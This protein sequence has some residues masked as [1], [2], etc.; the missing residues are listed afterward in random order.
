MTFSCLQKM[1]N[2]RR[3]NIN[4]KNI[5]LGYR[6]GIYNRKMYHIYNEKVKKTNN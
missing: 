4:D 3:P 5:Q 1:K 6:N 2:N